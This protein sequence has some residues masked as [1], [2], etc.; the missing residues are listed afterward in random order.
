MKDLFLQAGPLYIGVL[1]ILL[2]VMVAWVLY[3]FINQGDAAKAVILSRIRH[4]KSIGLFALMIGI[5]FQL[6]GFYEA[7]SILEMVEDVLDG[8]DHLRPHYLS[9]IYWTVIYLFFD[10]ER[11]KVFRWRHHL[12]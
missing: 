11:I 7:F 4:S 2:I 5:L 10:S 9:L 1:T 6:I 12:I 3:S 8:H